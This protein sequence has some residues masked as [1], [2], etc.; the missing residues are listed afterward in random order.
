MGS[1]VELN[2]TLQISK[3]QGFPLELTIEKHLAENYRTKDIDR[4]EDTRFTSL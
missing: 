3:E 2:D 4:N 1:T